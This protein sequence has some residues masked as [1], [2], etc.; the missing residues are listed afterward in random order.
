MFL[1]GKFG[2]ASIAV[3]FGAALYFSIGQG[4]GVQAQ[5]ARADRREFEYK[6]DVLSYNPGE[7]LTDAQRARQFEMLLNREAKDGWEPVTSLLS[8]STVQTFGGAITT[9]DSTSFLAFRRPR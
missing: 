3:V 1:R 2:F 4:S 6:V 8:R 9:R 5:R 7:R